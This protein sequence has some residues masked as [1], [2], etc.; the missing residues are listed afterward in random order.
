[1]KNWEKMFSAAA[2]VALFSFSAVQAQKIAIVDINQVLTSVP[3][4]KQSQEELDRIA[5]RW[6]SE[7]AA[8][9]DGIKGMY[10][11]FQAEQVL[12]S[13]DARKSREEEIVTKEKAVREMQRVKF[14]PEGELFRK[15]QELVKP[16]QDKVYA[17]I[18]RFAAEKGFDIVLDK[19][20]SSGII[21]ANPTFDKTAMVLEMMKKM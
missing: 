14:G 5:Q 20:S 2:F 11:K 9:Q 15:R 8:E 4:Y 19:S 18:E 13:T 6:R 17:A 10:S 7:I 21:F 3:S 16:I 12:L 1:M